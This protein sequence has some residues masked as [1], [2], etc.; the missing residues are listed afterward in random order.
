MKMKNVINY[1][2]CTV[3]LFVAIVLVLSGSVLWTLC[4]LAWCLMLYMWGVV[5]PKWWK[6]FWVSNL[7]F[8]AH[9]KCL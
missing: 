5:C 2:V 9:F 3:A 8:L 1:L 6:M 4:G 7:R